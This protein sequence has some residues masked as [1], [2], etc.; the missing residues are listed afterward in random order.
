LNNIGRKLAAKHTIDFLS[1]RAKQLAWVGSLEGIEEGQQELL[2]S[3]YQ[4]GVYDDYTQQQQL[5][6]LPSVFE[7]AMLADEAVFAYLGLLDGDPD[8][9]NP[10]LRRAM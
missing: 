6:S 2:Q 8:N 5:F 3:R 7:D 1:K 10:Q 9:A 4:R